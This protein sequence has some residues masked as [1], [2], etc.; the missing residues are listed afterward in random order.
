MAFSFYEGHAIKETIFPVRTFARMGV[1]VLI[2]T[3]AAGGL[4]PDYE[5]CYNA[6]L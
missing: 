5:V 3:N 1:E 6:T 2:T 4:N